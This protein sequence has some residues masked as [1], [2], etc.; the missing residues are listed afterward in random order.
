LHSSSFK[1][2]WKPKKGLN[3]RDGAT[4]VTIGGI[5]SGLNMSK[6]EESKILNYQSS[7]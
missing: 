4:I 6:P 2:P 3:E 5:I 1:K 7:L